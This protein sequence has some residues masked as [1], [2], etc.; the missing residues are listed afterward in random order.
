MWHARYMNLA[1]HLFYFLLAALAALAALQP[2]MYLARQIHECGAPDTSTWRARYMN[3]ARQVLSA[4]QRVSATSWAFTDTQH[5]AF[6]KNA[7]GTGTSKCRR[8]SLP[9][10]FSAQRTSLS[11]SLLFQ[12]P[13]QF[14]P[15]LCSSNGFLPAGNASVPVS[16]FSG[17]GIQSGRILQTGCTV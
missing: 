1:C 9:V 5:K 3:V 8:L 11:L 16:K 10:P 15:F 17:S 13:N 12:T 7:V 2:F 14:R 6:P 4:R